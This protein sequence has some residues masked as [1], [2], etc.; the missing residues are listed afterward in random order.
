MDRAV[1][2]RLAAFADE[3]FAAFDPAARIGGGVCRT[4]ERFATALQRIRVPGMTNSGGEFQLDAAAL[5]GA[6]VDAQP[7]AVRLD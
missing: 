7:A 1:L 2:V 6:A 5:A 4:A 3:A